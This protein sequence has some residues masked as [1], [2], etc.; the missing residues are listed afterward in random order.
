MNA[1][2]MERVSGIC[3][4]SIMPAICVG[5]AWIDTRRDRKCCAAAWVIAEKS[6]QLSVAVWSM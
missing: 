3:N 5:I 6:T 2:P 1:G 4:L